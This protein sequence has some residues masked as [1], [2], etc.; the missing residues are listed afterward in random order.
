MSNPQENLV[1]SSSSSPFRCL[2][3]TGVGL[4]ILG[5]LLLVGSPNYRWNVNKGESPYGSD[6]LQDWTGA[7]MIVSG[8]ASGLFDPS[9]F[10]AWQHAPQRIG[11][12][13][14]TDEYYPTVYPPPY[15]LLLSPL[16]LVEYRWAVV[17]WLGILLSALFAAATILE[18]AQEKSA[19]Q[20]SISWFWPAMMLFPPLL[21]SLT[22][23]QKGTLW[24]LICVATW[25]LMQRQRPLSAGLVFGL[26][27][28]KPTLFF[29]L[30]LVM[31][32]HRQW[33]F[34]LGAGLSFVGLWLA[35]AV[36]LP[37]HVWTEFLEVARSAGSY[38]Q[39]AGY[40]LHWSCNLLSLAGGLE[41]T[42]LPAWTSYLLLGVLASYVLKLTFFAKHK[43]RRECFDLRDGN[44]LGRVV[45]AT[46][47]L[48]PHFYVYDLVVLLLPIR[49]M[50]TS[51]RTLAVLVS[52]AVWSGMLASQL[53]HDTVGLPLM[54]FVLLGSLYCLSTVKPGQSSV[55]N[56]VSGKPAPLNMLHTGLSA[57]A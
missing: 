47:L 56:G 54:P 1:L 21:L 48:S 55:R 57:Q 14:N 42:W 15:Y 37:L 45:L 19:S 29:F 13:W 38:H 49:L 16:G 51:H 53:C 32:A 35:A 3:A 5:G 9:T 22:M 31:L 41:K 44:H 24:L 27:S 10:D 23:G 11:F 40:Q 26:L 6:F 20:N 8:Q 34:V 30:P 2:V 36:V 52:S 7:N 18:R 28:V 4:L 43:L 17:L 39:H 50:W 12:T 25:G 33:R 46:C